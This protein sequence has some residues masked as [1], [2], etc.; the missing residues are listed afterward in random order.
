MNFNTD[1]APEESKGQDDLNAALDQGDTAFVTETPKKQVS[2]GTI[3]LLGLLAICAGGTYFMYLRGGPQTA[4]AADTTTAETINTFLADGERHV[5]LMK[6]ML[7][8]T[9]KVVMRFRQTTAQSQ[10]PL[11]KLHTNP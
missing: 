6:E 4:N 5:K 9:D 2:P 8:E 10:I 7:K 1:I 11:E 3:G